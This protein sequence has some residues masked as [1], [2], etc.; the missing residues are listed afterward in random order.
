MSAQEEVKHKYL[1]KGKALFGCAKQQ[2]LKERLEQPATHLHFHFTKSQPIGANFR[3]RF[4]KR[5]YKPFLKKGFQ[6]V[7]HIV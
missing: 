4:S 2:H 5:K 7:I 6:K 3:E 1:L